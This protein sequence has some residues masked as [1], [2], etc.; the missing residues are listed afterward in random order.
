MGDGRSGGSR[1]WAWTGLGAQVAFVLGWLV[2]AAWQPPGYSVVRHS[3][4]D[5]YAVTAPH[6]WFL[7]ALLTSCGAA[8]VG[9]A[10]FAVRPA[11]APAGRRATVGSVLL[12]V[13]IFGLG[14]LL[15]PLEQEACQRADPACSPADQLAN[16]GGTLDGLLSTIGLVALVPA[17]FLLASAMRRLPVWSRCAA[18]TRVLTVAF[19]VAFLATGLLGGLGGLLERLLAAVGAAGIALLAWAV[20]VRS[21]P[22]RS[23]AGGRD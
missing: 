3:I 18:P 5:M 7:V 13:S 11:L 9:L 4:S 20:L 16:L 15:S 23:G 8:T 21:S 1:V 19:V 14:D 12:A 10:W 6:A 2:A 22:A 17:G